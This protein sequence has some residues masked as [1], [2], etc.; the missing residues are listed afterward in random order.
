MAGM[1]ADTSGTTTP[2]AAVA[3]PATVGVTWSRGNGTLPALLVVGFR[4]GPIAI[5]QNVLRHVDDKVV[6]VPEPKLPVA[7]F[8]E[9]LHEE[10]GR[11]RQSEISVLEG[12]ASG[13]AWVTS[14]GDECIGR[15]AR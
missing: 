2:V 3:T 13:V 7:G 11:D 10:R 1:T 15:G 12:D 8:P 14:G 4:V 6:V 5:L 9:G